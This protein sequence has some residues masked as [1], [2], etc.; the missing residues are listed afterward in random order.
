[1]SLFDPRNTQLEDM[2]DMKEQPIERTDGLPTIDDLKKLKKG[3]KVDDPH[4]KPEDP[5]I[6]KIDGTTQIIIKIVSG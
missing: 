3:D 5:S 2:K 6:E 4:A 1:M